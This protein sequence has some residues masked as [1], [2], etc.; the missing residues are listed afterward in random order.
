[1]ILKVNKTD[2]IVYILW[3]RKRT[4]NW[5]AVLSVKMPKKFYS[6]KHP[7]W[8]R[9]TRLGSKYVRHGG[10]KDHNFILETDELE[11]LLEFLFAND[12]PAEIIERFI[13]RI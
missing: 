3:W 2:K 12:F 8:H 10:I 1:M 4:V 11:V 5:P 7:I 6:K 13:E 9:L